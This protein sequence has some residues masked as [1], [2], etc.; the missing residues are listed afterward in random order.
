MKILR[1]TSQ[2][3]ENAWLFTNHAVRL[4]ADNPVSRARSLAPSARPVF[5]L[6]NREEPSTDS[7][8]TDETL[9]QQPS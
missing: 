2:L 1:T 6:A 7:T 5:V 3:I 9:A 8:A 4:K